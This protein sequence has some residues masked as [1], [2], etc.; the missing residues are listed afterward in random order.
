MKYK[1]NYYFDG[2]GEVMVEAKN[3]KEAKDK[4]F[5]GEFES[6]EEWGEQYNINS[7]EPV[8]EEEWAKNRLE[9]IRK[10]IENESVSYGELM[11]LQSLIKYID[12]N[13]MVLLEWA[14]C[15]VEL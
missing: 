9:S 5:E 14:S 12:K 3:K 10:S 1:I 4:F 6:E 7:I 8:S 2:N 11:A 15:G 13:D